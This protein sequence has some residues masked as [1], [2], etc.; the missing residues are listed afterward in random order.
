MRSPLKAV[1]KMEDTGGFQGQL[2]RFL[3]QLFLESR[4]MLVS[5]LG[6]VMVLRW[7]LM[8]SRN[9]PHV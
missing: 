7:A 3:L 1:R 8:G 9:V 5:P 4:E 6:M 2:S